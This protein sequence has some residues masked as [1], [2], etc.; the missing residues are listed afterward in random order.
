MIV[1][2]ALPARL[3]G[4]AG[5]TLLYVLITVPLLGWLG[6][7]ALV[8]AD[9][10]V[11]CTA[12]LLGRRA[13]VVAAILAI[14]L[15][16]LLL[17]LADYPGWDTIVRHGDMLG[18]LRLLVAG[19]LVGWLRALIV[20]HRAEQ[21][22]LRAMI[23][24]LQ[25]GERALRDAEAA[26]QISERR[27][28]ALVLHADDGI[29]ITDLT[30][31][32][33]YQSPAVARIIGFVP[34]ELI[35]T[36][37]FARV[38]PDDR[39]EARRLFGELAASPGA[40]RACELRIRHADETWRE[41]EVRGTNLINEPGVGGIV[42]NYRDITER[43]RAELVLAGQTTILE[44]IAHDAPLAESLT[45]LARLI[46]AI[47]DGALISVRLL[48]EDGT[49]LRCIAAPSLPI[50]FATA[51][52]RIPVGEG[53]GSCGTA[54]YRQEAVISDDIASDPLWAEY[55]DFALSQGLGACWSIPILVNSETPGSAGKRLLGTFAIYYAAPRRPGKA[56]WQALERSVSLAALAIERAR[57]A[58]EREAREARFR[59]LVQYG[60]DVVTVLDPDGIRRYVSPSIERVLGYTPEELVGSNLLA[61]VHP[62]DNA[63]RA[64]NL[65]QAQMEPGTHVPVEFRIHHRD[66][67]WRYWEAITTNLLA[68][69]SVG[70][71]VINARDVTE[72]V[73]AER[74]LRRR[75][76]E[77]A[78]LNTIG[79]A[80][81]RLAE[82]AA[83]LALIDDIVG[84]VLDNRNLFI[85]LYD[86]AKQEIVFPLYRIDGEPRQPT[87]RPYGNGLT[88]YVIRTRAP[89][90]IPRDVEATCARLGIDPI[91]KPCASFLA[92]PMLAGDQM[93][94]V[95]AVQKYA[96]GAVYDVGHR[97]LLATIAAQAAIALENA[98]L[99]AALQQELAER[100]RAEA[101]L[102]HQ[103]FHDSLTG[104]PNRALFLD[105]LGHALARA[106]REARANAVLFLDLDRFK[107][108][109]DSCGH[110]T[111]DQLLIAVASRLR[112]ALRAEDTLSRLGGDEF[113]VLLEDIATE[114]EATE[115][116]M[117]LAETLDLPFV[118]DGQEHRVAASIGVVLSKTGH[119]RPEDVLRDADVAMYRAKESGRGQYAVFD[120]AIQASLIARLAL[121]RDLRQALVR[122]EFILHYQPK[123]ALMTGRIVGVEALVRWRHPERGLI[124]PDAFIPLAEETGLIIPLG[125]WVLRESC[126]MAA[127]WPGHGDRAPILSVNLSARQFQD[128]GLTEAIT[129]VLADTG[130]APDRLQLEITESVVAINIDVAATALSALK[131]LGVRLALDDFGTGYSSLGSLK[132]FPLDVLKIDKGFVAGLGHNSQDEAIV[133]AVIGLGHALGLVVTAEGVETAAQAHQLLALGC[134]LG[135]GYYFARPLP[136]E[137]LDPLL[138][139]GFLAAELLS[140]VAD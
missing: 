59:A 44:Q 78:A 79:R 3:G 17:N 13:G 73:Q 42:L 69:P 111:G 105:R 31:I 97:D 27:F 35:G 68:E 7:P 83:I 131:S 12:A 93:I 6:P 89:L 20:R 39:D 40:L 115:V 11:V 61:L 118:I 91:G 70:G 16:T 100:R 125:R 65:A 34:E 41:V 9:L 140:A 18:P 107:D 62:E 24:Q 47:S 43:H 138:T 8:L 103:A 116:A 96:Q 2:K 76:E 32:T 74:V 129:Q 82:P 133:G 85:A 60:S 22:S 95:I 48:E 58:E 38:H 104:L 72:R 102:A 37:I 25:E 21:D 19:L 51:T 28:R 5:I 112:R 98:R 57:A 63:R 92:V 81:N 46:E 127:R 119:D 67:S 49:T 130:L 101:E 134:E 94:G 137:A 90:L 121:E 114:A 84:Q 108:V 56:E 33:I 136:P 135:Q 55:A 109:N 132:G 14:S 124:P 52:E 50:D 36:D 123:V 120:P 126:T 139:P 10:L 117:R 77:L 122:D 71:L 110:D 23:A 75:N 87:S 106:R 99:Y 64:A 15:N 53:V 54:A 113:T 45:A 29:A 4:V 86:Q 26:Q 66:G 128:P 30:G 88:D 1:T 80:L